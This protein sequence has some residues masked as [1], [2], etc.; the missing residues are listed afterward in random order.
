MYSQNHQ[1]LYAAVE[2]WNYAAM[3]LCSYARISHYLCAVRSIDGTL[4]NM[5]N[6]Y[7]NRWV[8]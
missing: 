1:H 2:L 8:L 6:P 4:L 5:F 3:E 7:S